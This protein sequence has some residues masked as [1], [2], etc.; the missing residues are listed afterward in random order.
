MYQ[1]LQTFIKFSF[2]LYFL[3][4]MAL[5]E[6]NFVGKEYRTTQKS[7]FEGIVYR[8]I[9]KSACKRISILILRYLYLIC[10]PLGSPR[11]ENSFQIA[12]D[13]PCRCFPGIMFDDIAS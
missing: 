9:K 3:I 6:L 13:K 8:E 1:G 4:L 7:S 12:K 5:A 2:L 10:F 11:L